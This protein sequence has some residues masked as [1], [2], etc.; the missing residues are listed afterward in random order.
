MKLT[1]LLIVLCFTL[2]ECD[3][4][5]NY[6]QQGR[7]LKK[8]QGIEANPYS[9]DCFDQEDPNADEMRRGLEILRRK[10]EDLDR[11]VQEISSK[12]N[13]IVLQLENLDA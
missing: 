8:C 6:D 2:N 5:S 12:L 10:N 4:Q 1:I 7:F 11:T 3:S 13:K 9:L